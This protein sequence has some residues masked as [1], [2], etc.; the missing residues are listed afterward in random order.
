MVETCQK[1]REKTTEPTGSCT[2]SLLGK[3][4]GLVR[5]CNYLPHTPRSLHWLKWRWWDQQPIDNRHIN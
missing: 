4:K 5:H 1:L 2:A 3:L